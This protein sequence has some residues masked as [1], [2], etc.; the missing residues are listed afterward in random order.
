MAFAP[1]AGRGLKRHPRS[2][3]PNRSPPFAPLAGRG[4]KLIGILTALQVPYAFA[5]LA[6]R[7]LKPKSRL[8]EHGHDHFRPARGARI[9]TELQLSIV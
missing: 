9:E 3:R 2:H 1:L 8:Y 4:L 5:P 7:G 6:G